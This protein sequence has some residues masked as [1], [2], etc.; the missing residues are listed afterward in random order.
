MITMGYKN[1]SYANRGQPFET[2]IK[3]ANKRYR[4]KEVGVVTKQA[5]EFIP[6]RDWNGKI[7]NVKVE[8]KATVD[9]LGRYKQ[10]PI[11]VEAKHTSSD[12]IRWDE[13]Q[14]HQADYMDD[15]I[16][17]G[18]IGLVLISFG[19]KRFFAI[20]WVFWQAAYNERVRP[21]GARTTPVSVS[22]FGTT[23]DIPKKNSVRMDEIPPEFEVQG[24][25][26]SYG[27]HYL[28]N[29]EKYITPQPKNQAK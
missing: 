15:F 23:W 8:E 9:F 2:F 14:E 10:Y 5:T 18:T 7:V 3:F 22:A 17:P 1:P 12:S 20:P 29:A 28:V 13:V 11:A 16:V 27:L 19:L 21:G 6:I 4:Q 26:F 25:D 24:N